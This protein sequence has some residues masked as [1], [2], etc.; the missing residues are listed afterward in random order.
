MI[1]MMIERWSQRDGSEEWLWSIWRDGE[2]ERM[3]GPYDSP[4]SAETE[5]RAACRRWLGCGPDNVTVL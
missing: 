2:R 4:E 1:E 5:G 3:D